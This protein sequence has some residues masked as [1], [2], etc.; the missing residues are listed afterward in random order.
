L[1]RLRALWREE[2]GALA[3]LNNALRI[4]EEFGRPQRVAA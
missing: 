1:S 3:A 4:V 2:D